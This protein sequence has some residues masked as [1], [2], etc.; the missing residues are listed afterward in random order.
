MFRVWLLTGT[1]VPGAVAKPLLLA[2]AGKLVRKLFPALVQVFPS[3][4]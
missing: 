1:V 4:E 2:S 3:A